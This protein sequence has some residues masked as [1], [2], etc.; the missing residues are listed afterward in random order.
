MLKGFLVPVARRSSWLNSLG[1]LVRPNFAHLITARRGINLE[2]RSEADCN[3]H[4]S[5][6]E[7]FCGWCAESIADREQCQEKTGVEKQV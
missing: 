2:I 3:Y 1:L 5:G 4:T 7:S 6:P